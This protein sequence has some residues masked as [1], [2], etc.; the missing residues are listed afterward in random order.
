MSIMT[1]WSERM[2]E[3]ARRAREEA[4]KSK[5]PEPSMSDRVRTALEELAEEIDLDG[6]ILRVKGFWTVGEN[7]KE[8]RDDW[9]R[10]SNKL[11]GSFAELEKKRM[12]RRGVK[13]NFTFRFI[14]RGT[15][16][17]YEDEY[18]Y[19]HVGREESG[20]P[21]EKTGRKIWIPETSN[22]TEFLHYGSTFTIA[23]IQWGEEGGRWTRREV[24]VTDEGAEHPYESPSKYVISVGKNISGLKQSVEDAAYSLTRHRVETQQLPMDLRIKYEVG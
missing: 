24:T 4:A 9:A 15:P 21:G 23:V 8:F 13:D 19:T 20:M 1:N 2:S 11:H 16:G 22:K 12:V 7:F 6:I 17:H 10:D 5:V 14:S 3:D 18:T